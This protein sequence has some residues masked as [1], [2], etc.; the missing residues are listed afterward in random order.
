MSRS[1]PAKTGLSAWA[2]VTKSPTTVLYLVDSIV[3]FGDAVLFAG[4]GFA[5]PVQILKTQA[6]TAKLLSSP[7]Q[8]GREGDVGLCLTCT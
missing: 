2:S 3:V 5:L 6:I 1:L 8:F 4:L 7:T